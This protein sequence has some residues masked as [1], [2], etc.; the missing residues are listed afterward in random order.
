MLDLFT[1]TRVYLRTRLYD[2]NRE[3]RSYTL[4][5]KL[6][7]TLFINEFTEKVIK[8]ISLKTKARSGLK[9]DPLKKEK[10]RNRR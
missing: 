4:F 5:F 10:R 1:R 9:P 8:L 3:I 7:G 6:N 2:K